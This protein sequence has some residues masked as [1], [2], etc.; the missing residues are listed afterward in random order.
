MLAR[1]PF[2]LRAAHEALD[3]D[4]SIVGLMA[5]RPGL[6][7]A[8]WGQPYG[9]ALDSWLVAPFV[10]VLGMTPEAVRL[11]YLLASLALIPLAYYLGRALD[12][13][14]ALP[15]AL[16]MACPSTFFL[17]L[18]VFPLP[19]YPTILVLH[20]L[21]FLGAL[22]LT[23][24][25]ESRVVGR[26]AL[27]GALAGL[28]LW[29]HLVSLCILLACA[30][31]VVVLNRASGQRP[32]PGL[33]AAIPAMAVAS[34]PLWHVLLTKPSARSVSSVWRSGETVTH[35]IQLLPRFHEP[36]LTVLGARGLLAP[37]DG[38]RVSQ[39]L[40]SSLLVFLYLLLLGLALRFG[41]RR[42]PVRMLAIAIAFVCA[43]FLMALR[44]TPD[45]ARFLAPAY[46]P[47]V[48]L[49]A[50]GIARA[51]PARLGRCLLTGM[52]LLNAVHGA[53]LWLE[54]RRH[55]AKE[56]LMP[57]CRPVVERLH[58]RGIRR[59]WASYHM[60]Y[61]VT[62]TS[63]RKIVASQPWNER[64][65]G[66]PLPYA[67]EV[68]FARKVAWILQ[69]SRDFDLPSPDRFEARLAS[70]GA[71]WQRTDLGDATIFDEFIPPFS[72]DVVPYASSGAAA[73]KDPVTY[74]I[75]PGQC[76]TVF[77]LEK[78]TALAGVT[79]LGVAGGPAL[80]SGMSVEV[81]RD[82][83]RFERVARPR[84]GR[85]RHEIV[86]L[87][88]QPQSRAD[89]AAFSFPLSGITVSA[90]RVRPA[91]PQGPWALAELLL[92]RRASEAPWDDWLAEDL[93]WEER[94]RA[95]DKWRRRDRADWHYRSLI[96]SRQAS[97][98][99][100]ILQRP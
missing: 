10:A 80:P 41:W 39:R 77:H 40:A 13:N 44:S 97:H 34:A 62:F 17:D 33:L 70:S 99:A 58:A 50:L 87:N 54:W 45:T 37:D 42:A 85:R 38:A 18:A 83:E 55:Q 56:P 16:L 75:A 4:T 8:F 96:V 93:S 61:C 98:A 35:L 3:G 63:G 31:H 89:G 79:L 51:R 76:A 52:L 48:A 90:I 43:A 60:A 68:K 11:P 29:T 1:F 59:A 32:R 64:F 82:G 71:R 28:A 100:K 84:S 20:G 88:G 14:A 57:D 15:A 81:S 5:Q 69:P 92:H 74:A 46:L 26:A 7:L 36:L 23:R 24:R 73:D 6:D 21:L 19:F 9:S 47:I 66:H 27:W 25:H 12:H 65:P 30:I 22:D 72:P 95:L 86:W 49:A 67:N 2:W 91:P 94:R 78:P 53:R